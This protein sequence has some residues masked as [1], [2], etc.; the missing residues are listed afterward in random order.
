MFGSTGTP[1]Q[2]LE[3]QPKG[4]GNL[5]AQVGTSRK[6]RKGNFLKAATLPRHV[7]T[8]GFTARMHHGKTIAGLTCLYPLNLFLICKF[9]PCTIKGSLLSSLTK[10]ELQEFVKLWKFFYH[11]PCHA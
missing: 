8:G 1:S 5:S 2:L 7:D 3:E 9:R 4:V 6:G 11:F 10:E